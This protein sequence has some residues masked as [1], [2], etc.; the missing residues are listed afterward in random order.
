MRELVYISAAKRPC[1]PPELAA[2]LEV[3]RR[4]NARLGVTGILLYD[5][6]SFIQVLEGDRPVMQE[7]FERIAQDPRHHRLTLIGESEI[8]Q[9]SFGE[10]TMGYVSLDPAILKRLPKRHG[11]SS[12]G[13]LDDEKAAVAPMLDA[14]RDGR[15]RSYING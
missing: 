10:W 12:N 3:S 15:W 14:F 6:G 13:S 9:R 11:L 7:L 8:A 2:I 5:A 1:A 4:N